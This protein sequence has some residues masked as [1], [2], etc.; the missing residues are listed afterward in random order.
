MQTHHEREIKFLAAMSIILIILA[1]LPGCLSGSVSVPNKENE[2]RTI[3]ITDSAGN[4]IS[5]NGPPQRIVCLNTD[6]AEVLAAI[7]AGDRVVGVSETILADPSMAD[8][9][10]NAKPLNGNWNSPNIESIFELKPD[11]VITLSSA[12]TN[13]DSLEQAGITVIRLDCYILSRLPAEVQILGRI[14]GHED[15]AI[16]YLTWYNDTVDLVNNRLADIPRDNWPT[17][18][19]EGGSD[20]AAYGNGSGADAIITM[21][22]GNNLAHIIDTPWPKVSSEWVVDQDPDFFIKVVYATNL[23]NQT[24][25]EIAAAQRNRTSTASTRAIRDGNVYIIDNRSMYGPRGL[26][27]LLYLCK[28]LYPERFS[29]VDV[30]ESIGILCCLWL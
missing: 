15:G 19:C 17:I 14:T 23:E 24:Y 18:Y 26:I 16:R 30:A 28:I 29:D 25:A 27:T 20:F 12:G 22:H 11:V 3:L 6:A 4:H 1:L 21:A 13:L 8:R 7:D 9:F 10:P 5:L 2:G